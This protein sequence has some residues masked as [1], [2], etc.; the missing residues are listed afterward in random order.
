MSTRQISGTMP[1]GDP[2]RQ[3]GS[4]LRQG[5]GGAA[6]AK[7]RP[8]EPDRRRH[9]RIAGLGLQAVI[10]GKRYGL[11][12]LSLGGLRVA[13][14]DG[15]LKVGQPFEFGL[16]MV[17]NGCITSFRGRA[18]TYRRERDALIAVFVDDQPYF[19]QTLCL[20]IE[21]E[22]AL[23][24]SYRTDANRGVPKPAFVAQSV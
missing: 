24:L 8:G 16:R 12:D 18:V 1:I 3:P 7:R 4:S 15:P 19:Y 17:V 10:G 11:A 21:Q 9:E 14:Y 23:R 2:A 22:R 5:D 20:Y 6:R 13:A